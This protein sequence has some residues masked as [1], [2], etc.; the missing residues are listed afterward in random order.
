LCELYW[1]FSWKYWKMNLA[2]EI[3]LLDWVIP[4][5]LPAFLSTNI[6]RASKN[7]NL[8][9]KTDKVQ[10]WEIVKQLQRIEIFKYS[11]QLGKKIRLIK[12]NQPVRSASEIARFP[13]HSR[14]IRK[15]C[16]ETDFISSIFHACL[17]RSV[18]NLV[19]HR[20]HE[21]VGWV[22]F[23]GG[24]G[25]CLYLY[26]LSFDFDSEVG[27]PA[28]LTFRPGGGVNTLANP[29]PSAHAWTWMIFKNEALEK[30]KEIFI[31]SNTFRFSQWPRVVWKTL[32]SCSYPN[33]SFETAIFSKVSRRKMIKRSNR[34]KSILER[35]FSPP[36]TRPRCVDH[37]LYSIVIKA[38]KFH[39]SQK[40]QS[41]WNGIEFNETD[42]MI[43]L[44]ERSELFHAIEVEGCMKPTG[45]CF[46]F[47]RQCIFC[48]IR[49]VR[50]R[51]QIH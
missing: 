16:R 24:G 28:T 36:W 44:V 14:S 46:R 45:D 49:S 23:L 30:S 4:L 9:E 10:K 13:V 42:R 3:V 22:K 41:T 29:P 20:R 25:V 21:H 50:W 35:Q 27:I 26:V 11:Q 48:R 37:I 33:R 39:W 19:A 18:R 6:Q 7:R 51:H 2:N 32:A 43:K 17:K 8:R 40:L 47:W 31:F 15:H 12:Y 1:Y 5:G 38:N 34:G